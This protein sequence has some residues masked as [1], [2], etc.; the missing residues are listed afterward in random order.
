MRAGAAAGSVPGPRCAAVHV[1]LRGL[2]DARAGGHG[3]RHCL[4]RNQLPRRPNLCAARRQRPPRRLPGAPLR[5]R[6]MTIGILWLSVAAPEHFAPSACAAAGRMIALMHFAHACC[7]E[8]CSLRM[9]LTVFNDHFLAWPL[10]ALP[11]CQCSQHCL[12]PTA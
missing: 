11:L 1:A 8:G 10:V 5:A 3:Q 7:Q 6:A 2:G 9:L 4:R 12:C